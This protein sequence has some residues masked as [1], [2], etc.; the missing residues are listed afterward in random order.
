MLSWTPTT[1][2]NLQPTTWHCVCL[3]VW[4]GGSLQFSLLLVWAN[5]LSCS[6]ILD[7]YLRLVFMFST[8]KWRLTKF[9]LQLLLPF[10]SFLSSVYMTDEYTK[11]LFTCSQHLGG[12]C[13]SDLFKW[14]QGLLVEHPEHVPFLLKGKF[15]GQHT[16]G[17]YF[18]CLLC[19]AG[20]F[21][22]AVP[23]CFHVQAV[24]VYLEAS[25]AVL[26]LRC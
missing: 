4:R 26:T 7:A 8:S 18:A 25:T 13:K 22:M 16:G 17:C 12:D 1:T 21:H 2:P 11:F 3:C 24:S 5:S 9:R 6:L 23:R 14:E 20:H 15:G 10:T 19:T